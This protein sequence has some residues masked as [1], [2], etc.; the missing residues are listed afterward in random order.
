M[1]LNAWTLSIQPNCETTVRIALCRDVSSRMAG[2][3][4]A[5]LVRRL[6]PSP[7]NPL[8]IA[9]SVDD[10]DGRWFTPCTVALEDEADGSFA[11]RFVLPGDVER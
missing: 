9:L 1:K 10:P 7:A 8:S 3:A 6:A 5:S 11:M 4:L 2:R